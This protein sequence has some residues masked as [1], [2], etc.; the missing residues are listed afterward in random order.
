MAERD[1]RTVQERRLWVCPRCR[2]KFRLDTGTKA[3]ETWH[4]CE[5]AGDNAG[6][7]HNASSGDREFSGTNSARSPEGK[8]TNLPESTDLPIP[9][10]PVFEHEALIHDQEVMIYRVMRKLILYGLVTPCLPAMF[11][12]P[13]VGLPILV[14]GGWCVLCLYYFEHRTSL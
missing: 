14:W 13:M 12:V 10:E 11:M 3:P 7:G 1:A 4:L 8:L 5:D 6:T 9:V 2:R